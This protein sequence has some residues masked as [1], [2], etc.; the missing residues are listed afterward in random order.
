MEE[1]GRN[2]SVNY[3]WELFC[4]DPSLLALNYA[5]FSKVAL[6]CNM[7][8]IPTSLQCPQETL[9]YQPLHTNYSLKAHR[10]SVQE[11]GWEYR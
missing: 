5:S 1:L 6:C 11:T 7:S 9:L 2:V 3:L 8:L 4:P 10:P